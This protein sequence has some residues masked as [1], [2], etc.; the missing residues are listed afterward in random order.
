MGLDI[1]VC[2][3]TLNVRYFHKICYVYQYSKTCL[4]QQNMLL[5]RIKVYSKMICKSKV[6]FCI[7]NKNMLNYTFISTWNISHIID[8]TSLKS[9]YL[10]ALECFVTMT[11]ILT[12]TFAFIKF[13]LN[14]WKNLLRSNILWQFFFFIQSKAKC[15]Y[16]CL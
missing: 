4:L 3:W 16:V 10:F 1:C 5:L 6:Q 11:C 7:L 9:Q 13:W 8:F 14:R 2:L 15:Q 12:H